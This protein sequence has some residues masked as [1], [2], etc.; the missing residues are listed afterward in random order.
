MFETEVTNLDFSNVSSASWETAWNVSVIS[1]LSGADSKWCL[2][3]VRLQNLIWQGEFV[4]ERTRRREELD[5]RR[6]CG[7]SPFRRGTLGLL[8]R[9]LTGV[10]PIHFALSLGNARRTFPPQLCSQD[11][12]YVMDD[13]SRSL[14]HPVIVKS[15]VR[16][17]HRRDPVMNGS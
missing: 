16:Y 13:G 9:F 12:L 8:A 14:S 5:N 3:F 4:S 2:S 6:P 7:K 15:T 1:R 10:T 17:V 11:S